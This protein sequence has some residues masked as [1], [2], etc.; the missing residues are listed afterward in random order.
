MAEL[1]EIPTSEDLTE[2]GQQIF[3]VVIKWLIC[4]LFVLFYTG[5]LP[6]KPQNVVAQEQ[7]E[8]D[9]AH[10]T[11]TTSDG[12]TTICVNQNLDICTIW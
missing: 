3:I 5:T 11:S 7:M 10:Q 2:S 6:L 4:V 12:M 1:N 9:E 8:V